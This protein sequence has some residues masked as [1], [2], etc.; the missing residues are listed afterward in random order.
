MSAIVTRFAP[1]P[2]GYLHI[3]GA[4]TALFNW[5]F[6]RHFGGTF[7][8][9]IEDTDRQRS[10]DDAIGKIFEGLQWLG[11]DWDG[12]VVHQFSRAALHAAEAH[13]LIAEG[14]AYYCY[15]TPDELTAM[16][17]EA[18]ANGLP[19][20]YNGYWRDR[21]PAEAPAGVKPAVRL[22]APREGETMVQDLVQGEVRFP[23]T[24]LDD[25]IL[26]RSDGTPT[27]MLSVVVDDHDMGITHVIRGDDHLT[28]T[29][30][31]TQLYL[32]LGW[33]VPAFAHI[34]LIH[35]A[36][37]AKL[38]KRHG[39]LGVDAYRDL[40]YLPEA[41]RNYLLRLGWS[42]GDDEIISTE[43]AVAWF[44][45]ES[46]GRSP[47][48]FDFAKLDN[49]NGHYL[50]EAD[51]AR[52]AGLV[53]GQ[54]AKDLGRGLSEIETARLHGSIEGLKARARTLVQLVDS[55]RFLVAAR[56]L[57]LDAKAEKVVA[58][59]TPGRDRL[60]ALKAA[61]ADLDSFS[62]AMIEG[63]ARGLA[64]ST[65]AKLGDIAQ[66]L[67]AAL[68]GSTVSPPIFEVAEVLGREETLGRIADVLGA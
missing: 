33:D 1:S 12:D 46:V 64:E 50:R 63:A 56:P 24:E 61:I 13:R 62:A 42:H 67:R 4:R 36:D 8:L 19:P 34:P 65:G 39:A 22:K 44:G 15:C 26:L 27:Y 6:A 59:G 2:T 47:A 48:R 41:M 7:R 18:K 31:Q 32:A 66:P 49:L 55:A 53:A 30:R 16:R 58:A 51:N 25:M 37:G 29:A 57:A 38:S 10:T 3:G 43:Q 5:L 52:L 20:R 54:L 11:L 68:S 21:D 28:N 9:R 17:E 23:N 35:G 14:K 40:G 60:A 45:L